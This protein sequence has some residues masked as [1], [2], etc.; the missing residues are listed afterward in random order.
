[1]HSMSTATMLHAVGVEPGTTAVVAGS[2]AIK[3]LS[4]DGLGALG[5]LVVGGQL[6]SLPDADPRRMRMHAEVLGLLGSAAELSSGFF[7]AAFLITASLGSA[8]RTVGKGLASPAH[9]AFQQHFARDNN[10]G[11]VCAKE[12]LFEVVAPPGPQVRHRVSII[13]SAECCLPSTT[14]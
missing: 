8:L 12:E 7:P 4:K 14:R 3:W 13:P 9:R 10:I 2:A 5:R 6:G 11:A 1:M